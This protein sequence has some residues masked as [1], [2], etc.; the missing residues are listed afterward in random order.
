M[1]GV[2]RL[3][4]NECLCQRLNKPTMAGYI[5]VGQHTEQKDNF[6][7]RSALRLYESAAIPWGCAHV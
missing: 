2:V 1:H 4:G 5:L 3:N 6:L 7:S